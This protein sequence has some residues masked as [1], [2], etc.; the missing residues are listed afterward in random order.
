MFTCNKFLC[1]CLFEIFI[2]W[3]HGRVIDLVEIKAPLKPF[4]DGLPFVYHYDEQEQIIGSEINPRDLAAFGVKLAAGEIELIKK[5]ASVVPFSP[6]DVLD[7]YQATNI[8]H[9]YE[10]IPSS[11]SNLAFTIN[12]GGKHS[13]PH[14]L[15]KASPAKLLQGHNAF[16]SCD[17]ELCVYA[18]IEAFGMSQQ[19]VSNL[20]DWSESEITKLDVTFSA[21]IDSNINDQAVI[22]ALRN[23][24]AGQIR[25][26]KR[27]FATSCIWNAGSSR[28]VREVY[29]KSYEVMG[30]IEDLEKLLKREPSNEVANK[31]LMALKSP[32][33]Q[34]F[35]EKA[36]R[37]EAKFKRKW[38]VQEGVPTKV[39]L[40][41]EYVKNNGGKQCL[42]NWWS[43]AWGP[44]FNSFKGGS[45]KV[46]SDE[47]IENALKS[48]YQTFTKSGKVSYS[49]ALRVFDFFRSIKERGFDEV[50]RTTAPR[51]FYDR[52]TLLSAVVPR[53]YLQNIKTIAS[54][55][56]PLIKVINVDFEKQHPA[57]W[58]EPTPM[59]EQLTNG[60]VV[61][62]ARA[63]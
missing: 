53:A 11:N 60:K 6:N 13:S 19:N 57:Q 1:Y 36:L 27:S 22:S 15:F 38:L 17:A 8:Y 34:K 10:S 54:N 20:C 28:C 63:S 48:E 61:S 14:V 31:Q 12:C 62:L 7:K 26:S 4:I 50:K 49:K 33:V 42:Q 30:Q 55:V 43:K 39:G 5:D 41:L 44:I 2:T 45:M 21:H 29:L 37:F 18:L 59:M 56:V 32:Q 58:V 51:T 40:F 35:I 47:N 25:P 46:Y 24:S 23:V 16:G 3:I 9:P 52:L